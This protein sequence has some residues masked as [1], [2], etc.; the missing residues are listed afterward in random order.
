MV[1]SFFKATRVVPITEEIKNF[2][3]DIRRKYR[4]ELPDCMIAAT[5][6]AMNISLGS[7]D[8]QLTKPEEVNLIFYQR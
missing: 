5:S 1:N 6:I 4:F 3:I 7:S 2:G 8:K